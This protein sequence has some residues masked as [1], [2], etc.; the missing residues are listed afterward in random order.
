VEVKRW[1]GKVTKKGDNWAGLSISGED[2]CG[3]IS[4]WLMV[5]IT[6]FKYSIRGLLHVIK[7]E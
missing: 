3:G 4:G 7:K 5:D 1:L 2:V 6:N